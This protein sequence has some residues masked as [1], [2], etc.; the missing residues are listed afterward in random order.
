MDNMV[1][2]KFVVLLNTDSFGYINSGLGVDA[3][4]EPIDGIINRDIRIK[5]TEEEKPKDP[6]IGLGRYLNPKD[7]QW[8]KYKTLRKLIGNNNG[9]LPCNCYECRNVN[10]KTLTTRE[11][12]NNFRRRYCMLL[13]NEQLN[14]L[15]T[16][17]EDY[18]VRGAL[19]NKLSLEN[20]G[21]SPFSLYK[22]WF[23]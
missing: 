18:S 10:K 21:S 8:W 7:L 9:H 13:R 16:N 11:P 22:N 1:E 12:W 3:F 5:K 20:M 4:S 6:F 19:F 17:I 14:E 2:D 23:S 15:I